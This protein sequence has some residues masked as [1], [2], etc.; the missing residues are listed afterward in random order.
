[1]TPEDRRHE[2]AVNAFFKQA[3]EDGRMTEQ[4]LQEINGDGGRGHKKT[5][6]TFEDFVIIAC[7]EASPKAGNLT[8]LQKAAMCIRI[9]V[10]LAELGLT[11]RHVELYLNYPEWSERQ[12]AAAFGM[13]QKSVNRALARVRRSWPSFRLDV[14]TSQEG[15][16]PALRNMR[17]IECSDA[18]DWLNENAIRQRF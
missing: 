13:R 15:E 14:A 16:S 2:N 12:L 10:R 4:E 1:M 7:H 6:K 8:D 5:L 3:I 9:D 18:T 11:R 17:R